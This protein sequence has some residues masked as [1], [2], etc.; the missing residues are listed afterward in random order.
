VLAGGLQE[1]TT[2]RPLICPEEE[3][4]EIAPAIVQELLRFPLNVIAREEEGGERLNFRK[5]AFV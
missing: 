4:G 2:D 1:N 3:L 5:C